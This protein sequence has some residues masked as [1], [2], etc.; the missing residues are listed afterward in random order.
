MLGKSI[1][2]VTQ[3]RLAKPPT[4]ELLLDDGSKSDSIS[5]SILGVEGALT[6]G[7]EMV[8]VGEIDRR[9][10]AEREEGRG[11]GAAVLIFSRRPRSAEEKLRLRLPFVG[12]PGGRRTEVS[13]ADSGGA[14]GSIS[15]SIST[16][17]IAKG[18]S[19]GGAGVGAA[20]NRAVVEVEDEGIG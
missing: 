3:L 9:P 19:D 5:L 18:A 14:M 12:V 2:G 10:P 7:D 20:P 16:S 4:T 17:S 6:S 11:A 8:S 13:K 15:I 1:D